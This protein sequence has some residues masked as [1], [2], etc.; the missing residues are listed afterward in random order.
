MA[1]RRSGK[2]TAIHRA[3]PNS[4]QKSAK[5]S[6]TGAGGGSAGDLRIRRSAPGR[7]P[8]EN[9]MSR[10][11]IVVIDDDYVIRLSCRQTLAKT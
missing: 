11:K 3:F 1:E 10:R 2:A 6:P 4:S 7:P 8:E 9:A 5:L